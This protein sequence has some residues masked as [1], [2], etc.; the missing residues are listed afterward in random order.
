MRKKKLIALQLV[1]VIAL[2]GTSGIVANSQKY[3]D[4]LKVSAIPYDLDVTQVASIERNDINLV[5]E[6]QCMVGYAAGYLNIRELPDIN[7]NILGK[8]NFN[9]EIKYVIVD[10]MWAE[11]LNAEITG[12]VCREYINDTQCTYKN[13][14][15]PYKTLWKSFMGYDSISS[16]YQKD[17]QDICYTGNYG[18]RMYDGRYCVAVG[19]ACNANIGDYGS[20]ILENGVEIPIVVGDI[21]ADRDTLENNLNTSANGCCSEF[22]VD[23]S[24]LNKSAM[25]RGNISACSEDWNSVVSQIVIYNENCLGL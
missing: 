11:V 10:D 3:S 13:V 21:K 14:S 9:E 7:S 5:S 12:Y 16:W 1:S 4:A 8:F 2:M 18:I 17:L 15:T 22:I 25:N 19:T 23:M 6:Q 20:L 24:C